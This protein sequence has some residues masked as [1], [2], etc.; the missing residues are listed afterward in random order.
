MFFTRVYRPFMSIRVIGVIVM[1]VGVYLLWH[2]GWDW[3]NGYVPLVVGLLMALYVRNIVIDENDRHLET[4]TGVFPFLAKHI[5]PAHQL[6]SIKLSVSHRDARN[7]DAP[8]RPWPIF[9]ATVLWNSG[10]WARLM[11]GRR[12]HWIEKRTYSIASALGLN[13]EQTDGYKRYRD[14]IIGKE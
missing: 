9:R 5:H 2:N 3:W 11:S 7:P 6:R 14:K 10:R 13:V 12:L 1:L 4:I 8:L